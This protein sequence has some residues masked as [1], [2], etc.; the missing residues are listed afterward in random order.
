[1]IYYEIAVDSDVSYYTSSLLAVHAI[2]ESRVTQ[3]SLVFWHWTIVRNT[4]LLMIQH[5]RE[6]IVRSL[7]LE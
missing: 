7:Y 5:V 6:D 3:L 4:H 1:M 2:A